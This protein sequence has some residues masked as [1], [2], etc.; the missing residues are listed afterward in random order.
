MI[1]KLYI[2]IPV[3]FIFIGCT[4]PYELSSEVETED[5]LV[6][7]A[8]IT[9]KLKPQIIRITKTFSLEEIAPALVTS[10]EVFVEDD[11]GNVYEFHYDEELEVYISN[12][13][14][15][16]VA[17][18]LYQL[19]INTEDGAYISTEEKLTTDTELLSLNAERKVIDGVEGIEI[20]ANS[21]DPSATSKY[22]RYTYEET[23]KVVAPYYNP[24]KL[25]YVDNPEYPSPY[26]EVPQYILTTTITDEYK[27]TCYPTRES[28]DIVLYSTTA[29]AQDNVVDFPVRFVPRES[30]LI[31]YGYS[32]EVTQ[33]VETFESYSFYATL[34]KF[35]QD[36]SVFSPNQPG[37][38]SG[39]LSSVENPEEK[40][41]GF[42]SVVSESSE[43]I[44]VDH[45]EFFSDGYRPYIYDCEIQ[46]FPYA[47]PD[48]AGSIS[49]ETF[50]EIVNSNAFIL[51]EDD[52]TN[53]NMVIPPCGD[54][55]S[56]ASP[57]PPEYWEE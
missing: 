21:F 52:G 12:S 50:I 35:S 40:V 38:I 46:V 27:G 14:F 53:Y 39:N 29:L 54:C 34:D 10:A 42:F 2:L 13:P 17:D 48:P 3:L 51:Y 16:A 45:E 23:F 56:F 33:Y 49:P 7:E 20:T 55:S 25:T 19:K 37:F 22:Y 57:E 15:Q 1:K 18:R 4:E 30:G 44:F 9:N 41:I 31:S 24:L 8:Q 43:R 11:A 47:S 28:E 32:I 26:G 5:L 6:V 36:G